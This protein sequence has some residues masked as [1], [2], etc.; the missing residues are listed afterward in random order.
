MEDIGTL[1]FGVVIGWVAYRTLRRSEDKVGLS[2]IATV[3]AAVGGGAVM[4]RFDDRGLFG[5]YAVGLAAGFF[6]YLIVAM[7]LEGRK[8]SSWMG[9]QRD[10]PNGNT[11]GR[12]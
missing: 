5:W 4:Q 9:A 12:Q 11:Y 3:I 2:D 8:V 10:P 1:L 6:G 7:L